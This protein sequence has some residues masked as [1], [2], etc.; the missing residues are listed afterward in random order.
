MKIPKSVHAKK[1]N[2]MVVDLDVNRFSPAIIAAG[3]ETREC[4]AST[5][6]SLKIIDKYL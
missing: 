5:S 2:A 4:E 3:V 1:I 6:S